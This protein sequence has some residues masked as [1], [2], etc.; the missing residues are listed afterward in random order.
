MILCIT[1]LAR[2]GK[3]TV[4]DYLVSDYGFAKLNMSDVLR[5]ELI[6]AGKE[7]TKMEMSK[8]GDEW[9]QK[10]GMDIVMRR[11]IEKAS[12]FER[13]VITGLRSIEEVQFMRANAGSMYLV[14][15]VADAEVRFSRRTPE[16]PK[17]K[18]EFFARDERDIKN[19]GFDKVIAAADYKLENNFDSTSGLYA[20]VDSL[21]SRLSVEKVRH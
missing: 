19:K 11:T 6:A 10:Y 1:S 16:D 21:M 15:V 9:R 8:L 4:A 5:D 3:D 18:E 2:A 12:R 7:P 17:T 20:E 14:A 13:A